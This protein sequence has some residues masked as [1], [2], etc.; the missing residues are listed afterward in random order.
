MKENKVAEDVK[1]DGIGD[2]TCT[3]EELTVFRE[4]TRK[5]GMLFPEQ[6]LHL[7]YWSMILD[8]CIVGCETRFSYEQSEVEYNM[9]V[10]G[11]TPSDFKEKLVKLDEWTKF[12]FGDEYLVRVKVNDKVEFRGKR[13]KEPPNKGIKEGKEYL[14]DIDDEYEQDKYKMYKY[15]VK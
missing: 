12:L 2:G 1:K 11:K 15:K 3:I 5:S 13:L 7:K 14:D 9:K 4:K 10:K 6:I 8:G